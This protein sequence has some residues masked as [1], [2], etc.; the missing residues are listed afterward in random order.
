M[1]SASIN[2]SGYE[3]WSVL[4]CNPTTPSEYPKGILLS[5]D[6]NANGKFCDVQLTF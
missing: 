2:D 5:A 6:A 1:Y 3:L 4:Y